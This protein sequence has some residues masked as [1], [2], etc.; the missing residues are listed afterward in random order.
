MSVS[1]RLSGLARGAPYL[2]ID[3][4]LRAVSF[5]VALISLVAGCLLLERLPA[6]SILDHA[7]L[8]RTADNW[9]SVAANLAQSIDS[10]EP[11]VLMVGGSATRELTGSDFQ[12]SRFMSQ[13][14]GRHLLFVNGGTSDQNLGDS[15]VLTSAIPRQNLALIIVGINYYRLGE[16]L[17]N[18][19]ND[20]YWPNFPF[21]Y[22]QQAWQALGEADYAKKSTR[23][24]NQLGWLLLHSPGYAWTPRK[25]GY[26]AL[27]SPTPGENPYSAVH[28]A[29]PRPPL[30]D[31]T[32][33]EIV[34]EYVA[35][36]WPAYLREHRASTELW[37]R[38]AKYQRSRGVKVVF[39]ALPESPSMAPA[40][41]LFGPIFEQSMNSLRRDGFTV[42][43]WRKMSGL[44]E[45]DFYD[46]Q[47]LLESGRRR[48]AQR[49][50]QLPVQSLGSCDRQPR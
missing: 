30:P 35:L 38:F 24:L 37:E 3:S 44:R 42:A 6:W 10:G 21:P 39:L 31:V 22:P 45:A 5:L 14:C 1:D 36:R 4:P 11:I 23:P 17:S 13:A 12:V 34:N 7:V 48:I 33:Q 16:A 19:P 2:W 26:A 28:N 47:H 25:R 40:D 8:R 32:K 46:Q 15:L 43:D 50:L 27:T 49:F 9:E 20:T 29:P 41:R 18:V